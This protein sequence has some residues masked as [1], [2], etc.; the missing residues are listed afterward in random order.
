MCRGHEAIFCRFRLVRTRHSTVLHDFVKFCVP[1]VPRVRSTPP[2]LRTLGTEGTQHTPSAAYPW[3]RRYAAPPLAC[4]PLEPRVRSTPPGLRTHG[5]EGTQCA[6]PYAYTEASINCAGRRSMGS[7]S[8]LHNPPPSDASLRDLNVAEQILE[9]AAEIRSL[10]EYIGFWEWLCWSHTAQARV[11]MLIGRDLYDV[12]EIFAPTLPVLAVDAPV[13]IPVATQVRHG[14]SFS[15][16]LN[17][18]C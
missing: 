9:R 7:M 13:H 15:I 16:F 18:F 14:V 1:S 11:Y 8:S 5:T 3:N 12:Q 2:R 17:C 4:V 6:R 10:G